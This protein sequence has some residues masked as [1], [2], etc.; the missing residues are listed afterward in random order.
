MT[1]KNMVIIMSDEHNKFIQGHMG[2][3]IIKTPNLDKLAARGT[4]FS[5]AYTT[6]PICVPARA[7]FATGRHVNEIGNW[8][9]AFPYTGAVP[10]WGH[11][12]NQRGVRCDSV[13]KL[14][15]RSDEDNNGFAR[16]VAPLH[17]VGGVGDLLGL[18]RE[19]LPVRKGARNLAL[20]A[21]RGESS[22]TKYDRQVRNNAIDW[23]TNEA[24]KHED[25]WVVFVSFVAP[26]FPL[27]AP[28]EFYD[29]YADLDLPM[30][31]LYNEDE[32]PDHPYLVEMNKCFPYDEPFND[33][34]MVQTAMKAYFGL[35]SF[36][37]D[38]VGRVV[39]AVDALGLGDNTD[40]LYV[41]DHGDNLGARGL[42]GKFVMYEESA[43][44][45]LLI[46]GPDIPAGKTVAEPVSFVDIMPTVMECAGFD[47]H[48]ID[49]TLPGT[50]LYDQIRGTAP[51]DRAVL[52]EYH[53]AGACTG[54]FMVRHGKYKYID[55]VGMPPM[56]FDLT[57]D[58]EE[59]ND[60]ASDPEYAEVLAAM[61]AKLQEFC[62]PEEVN[63]KALAAQKELIDQHGGRDA[64]L[65][66]GDFGYS[67]TP[68]QKVEFN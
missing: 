18:V 5:N 43:G 36:M 37:D 48:E 20:E 17:I 25:G 1:R 53:A 41:S 27:I 58:P 62:D 56:L 13:G 47:A 32:R 12:L 10:S 26:H 54:N 34:E 21:G 60:L 63:A 24:P 3:D 61:D 59:L 8:D 11:Y 7:S 55:Y 30:P 9:N 68:D 15:F 22:Y 65:N 50:S 57:A 28:D 16:E 31:K 4:K 19:E 2:H 51:K 67:P 64:V 33:K 6:C 38:N 66:R 39:D 29:L 35:V 23:L 42:W 52:S 45:P 46:A 14:H 44:I 49:P 40:I